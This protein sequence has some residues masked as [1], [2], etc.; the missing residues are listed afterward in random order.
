MPALIDTVPAFTRHIRLFI[1]HTLASTFQ[2]VGR[3]TLEQSLDLVS[4]D[5][6]CC[7]WEWAAG[8]FIDMDQH[9][10]MFSTVDSLYLQ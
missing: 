1:V 7:G 9:G 5:V 2:A 10:S 6:C 4:L 3:L 8:L